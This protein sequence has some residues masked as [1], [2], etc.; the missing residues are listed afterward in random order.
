MKKLND[1]E[2]AQLSYINQELAK[3]LIHTMKELNIPNFIESNYV[4]DGYRYKLRFE[5]EKI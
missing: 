3:I 4:S 5:R 1:I 2:E